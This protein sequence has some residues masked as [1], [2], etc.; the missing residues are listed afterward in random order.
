MPIPFSLIFFDQG[1]YEN[2]NVWYCLSSGGW[3]W[4]VDVDKME[5]SWSDFHCTL[6][7]LECHRKKNNMCQLDKELAMIRFFSFL[8]V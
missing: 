5:R 6:Y 8:Y 2:M 4:N 1:G 3:D 7:I